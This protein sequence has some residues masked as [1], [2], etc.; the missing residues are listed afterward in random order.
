MPE[1]FPQHVDPN[2]KQTADER[3]TAVMTDIKSEG[4]SPGS[5]IFADSMLLVDAAGKKVFYRDPGESGNY[6]TGGA[7]TKATSCWLASQGYES[8]YAGYYEQDGVDPMP[9]FNPAAA[10][11][12]QSVMP[13]EKGFVDSGGLQ[14]FLQRY[15][16]PAR[17]EIKGI[18]VRY[19]L[20]LGVHFKFSSD[21][22]AELYKNPNF[23]E[24]LN[25]RYCPITAVITPWYGE[26]MNEATPD[27][28]TMPLGREIHPIPD[29]AANSHSFAGGK[30]PV[31]L[32]PLVARIQA[33]KGQTVL[34]LETAKALTSYFTDIAGTLTLYVGKSPDDNKPL[35]IGEVPYGNPANPRNTAPKEPWRITD[36]PLTTLYIPPEQNLVDFVL[37][38]ELAAILKG[39]NPDYPK[40][41][42]LMLK[43]SSDKYFFDGEGKPVATFMVE[44]NY[45]I[46]NNTRTVYA[47]QALPGQ[48]T[49]QSTFVYDGAKKVPCTFYIVEKGRILESLP[50]D[51]TFYLIGFR[52]TPLPM[53]YSNKPFVI[54]KVTS[55]QQLSLLMCRHRVRY[56][57]C[58]C[59]RLM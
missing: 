23:W 5:Q 43:S 7:P 21:Q 38:A 9:V 28:T 58:W 34:S 25:E 27:L 6:D 54:E 29:L 31:T 15:A 45:T 49:Q 26:D 32:S 22:Y 35:P 55:M 51:E 14:A 16:D 44:P 57:T 1:G 50:S 4:S 42:T 10:A 2:D 39:E 36:F 24:R 48:P 20:Y 56:A 12:F 53:S 11:Y 40:G 3:T 17:G 18:V 13:F 33:Y 37:S 47:E 52:T 30:F 41:G 59:R 46:A 19:I 8:F